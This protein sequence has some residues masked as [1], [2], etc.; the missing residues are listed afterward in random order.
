MAITTAVLAVA[1]FA[2]AAPA[3]EFR[4]LFD[5]RT[6]AGWHIAAKPADRGGNFWTVRGGA[7]RCDSMGRKAHDYVWLVNDG[8]YSDFELRLKVRG[9]RESTGNSGVQVRSRFDEAAGRMDGPQVDVHPPT[10]WRTGLIYDETRETQRWIFPSLPDWKI[11]AS[12][13][14]ARWTWKYAGEGDGWNELRIVCRG[15]HI[16][17]WLNGLPMADFEGRGILDDAAHRLHRTGLNGH[18]AL[19]L[20]SGDELLIE[21]KDIAIRPLN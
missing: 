13:A 10:P 3:A 14:P 20:H 7:I 17:T 11:D 8:E 19:Q 9:Y 15:T 1:A 12:H 16:A 2:C 21:Y 4:P 6:L 18:I 5:G